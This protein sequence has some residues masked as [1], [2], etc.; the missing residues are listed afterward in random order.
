MRFALAAGRRNVLASV[1][2][3]PGMRTNPEH[4]GRQITAFFLLTFAITWGLQLPGV[5]AQRGLVPVDP[6][7]LMPFA[8]L[9]IFGPLVAATVLTARQGGRPLV[10]ELYGRFRLWRTPLG[11]YLVVLF[12][13]GLLLTGVLWLLRQAG[14]EGPIAYV[15]GGGRIV[16]GLVISVAEEVGWRG[17]ALPRLTKRFGSFA[18]SGLIGVVW[19]LWHI[20]MFLGAGV[21]LNL[22][23]VMVLL[24]T[25]GSLLMTWAFN[26]SG[27]SLVVAVAGHLGAHLNNSNLALPGDVTPLVVHAV[28]Y[29]ALGLFV[30]RSALPRP[31]SGTPRRN[32]PADERLL[33]ANGARHFG[34]DAPP[35]AGE[36]V[37]R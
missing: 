26:R 20:P 28:V 9:G 10:A 1:V 30:M 7:V 3:H 15:P 35:L 2:S 14:R 13:P 22:L 19:T 11:V 23:V 16:L 18:A 32:P 4:T 6:S 24:M 36:V 33:S 17:Y 25:G 34:V 12:L 31:R 37:A 21:P 27:G 8:V 29:A 5:M